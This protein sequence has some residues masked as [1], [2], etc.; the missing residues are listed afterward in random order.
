MGADVLATQGA[1]V[2]ATMIFTMFNS[3]GGGGAL[4][5]KINRG[6]QLEV[7]NGTQQDLKKKN[8]RFG[9]FGRQ[10]ERLRAEN[11]G[12]RNGSQQDLNKIVDM[13]NFGGQKDRP[14]AENGGQNRSAYL[15]TPAFGAVRRD[16]ERV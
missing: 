16:W 4:R 15:L 12:L 8:D 11:V 13:V 1:R 7:Q 14:V 2:S 3:R 10:K 6:A 5:V 9:Q